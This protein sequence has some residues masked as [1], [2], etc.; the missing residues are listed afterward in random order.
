MTS[1]RDRADRYN[2][3]SIWFHWIIAALV[4]FNLFVG[5]FHDAV[6]PLRALMPA[7][8]AVGI[9]V[10]VLTILRIV[11]RLAHPAPPFSDDVVAWERSAAKAVRICFYALLLLMPLSGW[12]MV[13]ASRHPHPISFFGLF[14]VPMLPVSQALGGSAGGVH[15]YLGYLFAVLAVVH[16]GAALRHHFLLRDRVLGRMV[17]GLTP[18]R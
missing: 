1:A 15:F 8:M 16:I 12:A 3:G 5:I 18:R 7:H 14:G 11:W 13:S 10:L 9:M 6:P 4:I 17:P 2:K